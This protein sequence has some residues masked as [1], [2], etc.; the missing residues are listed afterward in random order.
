MS[1]EAKTTLTEHGQPKLRVSVMKLHDFDMT[2]NGEDQ[3]IYYF[4]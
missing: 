4:S 1:P 2:P 3:M